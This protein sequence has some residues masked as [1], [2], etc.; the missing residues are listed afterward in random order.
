MQNK[1]EN[2]REE[3]FR[4]ENLREGNLREENPQDEKI[5]EKFH[6]SW[7]K[8]ILHT[9]CLFLPIFSAF[10]GYFLSEP[11]GKVF[12][13]EPPVPEIFKF[14][15]SLIFF[16]ILA[17][18]I[19]IFTRKEEPIMII[20]IFSRKKMIPGKSTDFVGKLH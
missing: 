11:I 7:Q 4:E 3:K 5:V 18:L 19:F 8:R 10:L 1:N 15:V 17:L 9:L 13:A 20:R 2:L 16:A 12:F 6:R 14:V